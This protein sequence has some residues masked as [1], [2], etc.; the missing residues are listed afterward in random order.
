MCWF[1]N[2]NNLFS[3]WLALFSVLCILENT[4]IA[5]VFIDAPIVD[6]VI[7]ILQPWSPYQIKTKKQNTKQ[8]TT[9]S[10]ALW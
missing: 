1:E 9:T 4:D 3:G 5:V 7:F 2:L 6:T 10:P 8:T